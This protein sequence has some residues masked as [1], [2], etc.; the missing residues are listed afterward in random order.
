MSSIRLRR[1]YVHAKARMLL[2][3]FGIVCPPVDIES[4]IQQKGI[5]LK[6]HL[7]E[8]L[9][10]PVTF[11]IRD[12][13]IISVNPTNPGR[14]RWSMAHEFAHIELGHFDLGVD[15][16]KQ[17]NLT[18]NERYIL[19]READLFA[20]DILMPKLWVYNQ[21]RT[22][23]NEKALRAEYVHQL[24][25]IFGVSRQAMSIRLSEIGVAQSI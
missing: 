6:Y 5:A 18:D 17:D 24:A 13:F 15:T 22:R 1:A 14:D 16:V 9:P 10:Y 8:D 3:E 21:I 2:A 25:E 4:I 19:D 11:K 12:R 20:R 7:I 23:F